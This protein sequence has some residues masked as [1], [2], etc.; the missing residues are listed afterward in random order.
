MKITSVG[1]PHW[2]RRCLPSLP[3]TGAASVVRGA[4]VEPLRGPIFLVWAAR[5]SL[6][7]RSRPI[8]IGRISVAGRPSDVETAT[9]EDPV[10]ACSRGCRSSTASCAKSFETTASRASRS[11]RGRDAL[12]GGGFSMLV[13]THTPASEAKAAAVGVFA[14]RRRPL[15]LSDTAPGAQ[16]EFVFLLPP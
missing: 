11:G 5:A 15:L 2:Q 16:A 13:M 12:R 1:F 14:R 10:P 3:L 8:P 4:A 9:S 6:L 7:D